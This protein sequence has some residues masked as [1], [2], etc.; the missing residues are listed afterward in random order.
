MNLL[1]E[2]SSRT[3]RQEKVPVSDTSWSE[4]HEPLTTCLR[5]EAQQSSLELGYP[6]PLGLSLHPVSSPEPEM[7]GCPTPPLLASPAQK[8]RAPG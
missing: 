8:C 3:A 4:R 6:P 2:G 7:E 5:A 1:E